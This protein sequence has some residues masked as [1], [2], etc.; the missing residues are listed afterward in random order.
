MT[1]QPT[2]AVS[3]SQRFRASHRVREGRDYQRSRAE[4]RRWSSRALALEVTR[5][6]G[7]TRLGLVVSRRVGGAVVRN[8]VKRLIR[9]WF[10]RS[11]AA[12]PPHVDLVVIARAP[13][14][15]LDAAGLWTDLA[16]TAARAAR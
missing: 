13:A 5:T 3:G 12:L 11:R 4:G 8:R 16:A 2:H 9:E 7:E 14:A 15:E 1:V 10:R 6:T